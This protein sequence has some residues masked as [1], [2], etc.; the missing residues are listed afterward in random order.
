[1]SKIINSYYD[2]RVFKYDKSRYRKLKRLLEDNGEL[3]IESYEPNN[4]IPKQADDSYHIITLADMNRLDLVSQQYYSSPFF[5]WVIAEASEI[6]DPFNI[7]LGTVLRIPSMSN[8]FS[9]LK[10]LSQRVK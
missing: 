5:W 6:N 9:N 8:L 7:P 3:Y 2:N 4:P 10:V 1:M